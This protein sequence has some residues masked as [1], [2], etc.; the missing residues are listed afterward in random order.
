MLDALGADPEQHRVRPDLHEMRDALTRSRLDRLREAHGL[1]HV[2][3]P[4]LGARNVF[5]ARHAAGQIRQE[6][7]ARARE[8]H[9]LDGR[10]QPGI[11]GSTRGECEAYGTRSILTRTP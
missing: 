6:R 2:G 11:N 5:G 9:A 8:A 1:S 7:A 4:I 3:H 10:A